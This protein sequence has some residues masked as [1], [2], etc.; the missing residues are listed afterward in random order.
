MDVVKVPDTLFGFLNELKENNHKEWFESNKP[1][2]QSEEKSL[3]K[4]FEGITNGLNEFDEIEKTKIFRIYKDVRFSKDKTPYKTNRSA[5]W[6]RAGTNRR[7]SYYLQLE[8]GN[9]FLAVGF[10]EPNPKDLLR[11]RKEFEMD[12][13]HIRKIFNQPEF[14][15]VFDGFDKTNQ[16]KTAPKGFDKNHKAIDL[17]KNKNFFIIHYF[18]DKEVMA[19]NFSKEVNRLFK[20]TIPFLNYMTEVVTTDLNGVSTL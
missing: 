4:F 17:I 10:F 2:F 6:M 15:K 13:S 3:K 7:G 5:N 18:S 8:P 9:S 1:R 19:S 16:V 12:D 20:L 11:F 14:K